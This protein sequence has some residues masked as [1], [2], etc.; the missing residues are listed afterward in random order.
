MRVSSLSDERVIRLLT[1]Y[2]VPV[3]VSRD[4]YQMAPPPKAERDE[5][6]RI[7]QE[8]RKRGLEG[9]TVSV[10]VLAPDGTVTH[11]QPVQK[12]YRAENLVPFL[13]GIVASQRLRPRSAEA[14]RASAAGPRPR[15]RPRTE[16]GMML[17]VY[18]GSEGAKGLERGLSQDW[19]E[20][21]AAEW[22]SLVPPRGAGAGASW[23]V[24]RKV[25][26]RPFQH[27]YPPGPHWSVKDSKVVSGALTATVVSTSGTETRLRLTAKLGLEFPARGKPAPGR[28]TARLVGFARY[29]PGRRAFT[30]LVLVSEEAKYVWD[31]KGRPQAHKMAVALELEP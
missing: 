17:H 10:N 12:A 31:W 16:G 21:T 23:G 14:I 28:V 6:A 5:L 22:S 20:L 19:V 11:T 13:E 15:P 26:D 4:H 2:F 3:W 25:A 24:P 27:C 9:G 30:R 1:Q 29:D 18:T 7:D 8:R